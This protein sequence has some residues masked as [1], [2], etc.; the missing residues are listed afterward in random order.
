MP[1]PNAGS[2]LLVSTR[3]SIVG[4]AAAMLMC[5]RCNNLTN[6]AVEGTFSPTV[7]TEERSHRQ[8]QRR[9]KLFSRGNV[10]GGG[11]LC[12]SCIF[13]RDFYGVR[14]KSIKYESCAKIKQIN[15]VYPPSRI[16]ILCPYDMKHKSEETS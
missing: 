8:Y 4:G 12:S 16:N 9:T 3:E 14:R 15:F 2:S 5:R 10:S 11:T 7:L 6:S 13:K 1:K